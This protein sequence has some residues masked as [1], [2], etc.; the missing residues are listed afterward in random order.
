MEGASGQSSG[1][2]VDSE[3]AVLTCDYD[4]SVSVSL[5]TTVPTGGR[6]GDSTDSLIHIL[7]DFVEAARSSDLG[8]YL[9]SL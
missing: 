3:T 9:C 2:F 6:Q 1:A 4:P 5:T 7:M 8:C